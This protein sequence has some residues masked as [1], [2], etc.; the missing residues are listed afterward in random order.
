MVDY[1]TLGFISYEDYVDYF[2]DTILTTNHTFDYFVDWDKVFDRVYENRTQIYILNSLCKVEEENLEEEFR[3]ILNDYPEVVPIL[4]SILAIRFKKDSKNIEILDKEL[5]R[6]NDY[7]FDE[8][9]FETDDIVKFC[10]ETGLLNLFNKIDNLYSY[11][12]GTEVGLDTNAR[13][14][15]SGTT[16]EEVVEK[17]IVENI[18]KANEEF[19]EEVFTYKAQDYVHNISRR[20]RADFI[21]YYKG[22]QKFVIEC[23][24]YS[25]T[26]SKPIEVASAYQELQQEL[27]A[28]DYQFIWI[29]D[30]A[31]WLKMRNTLENVSNDI[32]IIVNLDMF[33]FSFEDIIDI[34]E[35][36]DQHFS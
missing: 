5:M 4:P 14:N 10:R 25:K 15:R 11:L 21:I 33:N 31:G 6:T 13:K 7:N 22:V 3:K 9:F 35:L 24:F 18:K 26:G 20:K 36:L 30:G 19:E 27:S 32:D 16:F 8:D 34:D 2:F 1:K 17:C 23:N 12:V 28:E 29:T